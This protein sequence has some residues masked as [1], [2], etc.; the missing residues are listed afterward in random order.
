EKLQEFLEYSR[1]LPDSWK[2]Q[3]ESVKEE[4][5]KQVKLLED[6]V[7]SLADDAE[8]SFE[9]LQEKV[10]EMTKEHLETAKEH[11]KTAMEQGKKLKERL[12]ERWEELKNKVE[13]HVETLKEKFT[14]NVRMIE[15]KAEEMKQISEE[16][17]ELLKGRV[18]EMHRQAMVNLTAVMKQAKALKDGS[19]EKVQ[20][21]ANELV[22]LAE[23]R[24]EVAKQQLDDVR[25]K[26]REHSKK[27]NLDDYM[28][29]LQK[30]KNKAIDV[31]QKAFGHFQ[32]L[33]NLFKG[34]KEAEIIKERVAASKLRKVN[35]RLLKKWIYSGKN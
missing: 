21:K 32:R 12:S 18:L 10:L 16:K 25:A 35:K 23:Q 15:D 33:V 7:K 27:F 13:E 17:F 9:D 28:V 22:A 2:E 3:L 24:F 29:Y 1:T 20:K 6:R 26:L 14:K 11:L 31:H 30:F 34:K 19:F 8:D 4:T 5:M